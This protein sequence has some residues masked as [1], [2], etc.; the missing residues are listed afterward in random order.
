MHHHQPSRF[1]IFVQAIATVISFL[2]RNIGH[3]LWVL[4][5]ETRF[6][7]RA[8]WIVAPV[9]LT[10]FCTTFDGNTG[11][12]N[13]LAAIWY[14]DRALF[15]YS[16]TA[17][18]DP[19]WK[20]LYPE[21][22]DLRILNPAWS[23]ADPRALILW[24]GL[25]LAYALYY[26]YG[27]ALDVKLKALVD[28]AQVAYQSG[29]RWWAAAL[30][31]QVALVA[32]ALYPIGWFLANFPFNRADCGGYISYWHVRDDLDTTML[33]TCMDLFP[34]HIIRPIAWSLAMGS[35]WAG[36]IVIAT[37]IYTLL[38]ALITPPQPPKRPW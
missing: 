31:R 15:P 34:A 2:L 23:P 1:S 25:P 28:E 7:G 17:L 30:G 10:V 9:A 12:V 13:G 4:C 22:L 36:L 11:R 24:I 21:A 5:R 3:A 33:V 16:A 6:W 8:I 18:A 37:L 26:A 29:P 38:S 27:W 14:Y 35:G 19:F 32:Y 20:W